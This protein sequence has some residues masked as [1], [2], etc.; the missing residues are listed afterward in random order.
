MKNEFL[1]A[2]RDWAMGVSLPHNPSTKPLDYKAY[3]Q[4]QSWTDQ[5]RSNQSSA[6]PPTNWYW[7]ISEKEAIREWEKEYAMQSQKSYPSKI[8]YGTPK[9]FCTLKS[10][11][12]FSQISLD[13]GSP[14]FTM[15]GTG[16]I[17]RKT[18]SSLFTCHTT[19]AVHSTVVLRQ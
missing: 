17:P 15:H 16:T 14:F 1:G 5:A 7:I 3:S 11:Q 18:Y 13:Y 12:V 4:G 8:N 10:P 2:M 6:A 9:E 19:W